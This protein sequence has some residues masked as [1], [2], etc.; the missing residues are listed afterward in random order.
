MNNGYT[1]CVIEPTYSHIRDVFLPTMRT[2]CDKHRIPYTYKVADK[3]F[4]LHLPDG[5]RTILLK[6][7]EDP[8]KIVG[9]T[10]AYMVID[11]IDTM[12]LEKATTLYTNAK[13]R[14]TNG[15][16]MRMIVVTTPEGYSRFCYKYFV[17][18]VQDNPA[19]AAKRRIIKASTRKNKYIHP[20]YVQSIIESYPAKLANA[21]LDGDFVSLTNGMVYESFDRVKH[22]TNHT[23]AAF[24][25]HIIHIGLD[26]NFNN[27]AAAVGVFDKGVVYTVDEIV[28]LKN[29]QAMIDE[30]LKRYDKSRVIIYPD[31]AGA[32]NNVNASIS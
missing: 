20:D 12:P 23:L 3:H 9:F 22:H 21:Y 19:L 7:G 5:N 27:M 8:E 2:I 14:I 1:G 32:Q 24:P 18:D 29:T 10:C 17:Q 31:S 26:F 28:G 15:N 25:N 4:I 13:S 11:E 6:T 16:K 30:I